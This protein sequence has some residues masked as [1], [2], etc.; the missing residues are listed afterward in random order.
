VA[1]ALRT[2]SP[3]A[4]ATIVSPSSGDQRDPSIRDDA[5][6]V[7]DRLNAVQLDRRI[8]HHAGDLL[9]RGPGCA[10]SREKPLLRRSLSIPHRTERPQRCDGFRLSS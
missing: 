4:P 8:V 1:I 9:T 2:S 6:V 7:E 5:L 10:H 3:V